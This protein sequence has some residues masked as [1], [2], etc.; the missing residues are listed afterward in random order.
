MK[1]PTVHTTKLPDYHTS[2]FANELVNGLAQCF[3][4]KNGIAIAFT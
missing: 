3:L 2:N 1:S 4:A